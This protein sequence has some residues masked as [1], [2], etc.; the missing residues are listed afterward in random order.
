MF[1]SS[2]KKSFL[3]HPLFQLVG[4]LCFF[5]VIPFGIVFGV[6]YRL[7]GGA[8]RGKNRIS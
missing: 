5:L 2:P 1:S 6:L 7:F 4:A 8:H 3:G